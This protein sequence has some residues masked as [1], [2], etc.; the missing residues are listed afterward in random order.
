MSVDLGSFQLSDL[1]II[2]SMERKLVNIASFVK[3]S[4]YILH[5]ISRNRE[6]NYEKEIT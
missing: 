2:Q 3:H 4:V 1:I 5:G 6:L